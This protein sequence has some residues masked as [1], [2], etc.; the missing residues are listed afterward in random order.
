MPARRGRQ[1]SDHSGLGRV[2]VDDMRPE[3]AGDADDFAQRTQVAKR[4]QLGREAVEHHMLCAVA[5]GQLVR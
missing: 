5:P 4:V 3:A 2:G 1:P